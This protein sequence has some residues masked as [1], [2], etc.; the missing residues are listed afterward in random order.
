M[1]ETN[2]GIYYPTFAEIGE[3]TYDGPVRMKMMAESIDLLLLSN[4][5]KT[6]LDNIESGAEVNV[7]ETVKVNG[8]ALTPSN[9]AVDVPVPTKTSDLN[10]DSGFIDKDVNN[11]TNYYDKNAVDTKIS[12]VYKYKGTVST[13]ND[14]PSTNLTIGDVY[15]IETADSTH[16]VKAGDNVAWNGTAWDVLAGTVDLSG[17]QTKIDSS[18]KLESDLV[19]DTNSTHKFVTSEEKTQISTNATDI[20]NIKDGTEINSFGDVETVLAEKQEQIDALVEENSAFKK[21]ISTAH[22]STTST[23]LTDSA[24]GLPIEN[25]KLKMQTSQVQYEGRN[26]FNKD[27]AVSGYR[28]LQDGTLAIASDYFVTDFIEVNSSSS[29][30]KNSP[31]ADVYHRFAFYENT[32]DDSFISVSNLN[33]GNTPANC[34]YL[35]FCGLLTEIDT[36]Q[37]EL[38][39][40]AHD[41]EPFV[42]RTSKSKSI[43]STNNS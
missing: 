36:A 40:T 32:N 39:S 26:L 19:D 30:V 33:T 5:D 21:Q 11:L 28:L 15:N 17:Y 7:I 43:I 10:N 2:K 14:L 3:E 25:V 29:Y 31:T 22:I 12:A 16:G 42:G 34:N 1:A 8:I 38:G 4:E 18:H 37:L 13:Y 35:R 24:E 23:Q 27:T 9:K 41:W 6:K 20:D